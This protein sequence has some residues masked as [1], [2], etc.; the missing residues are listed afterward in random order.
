[1][2]EQEEE[3]EERGGV[4]GPGAKTQ[5][6]WRTRQLGK[7]LYLVC[8]AYRSKCIHLEEAAAVLMVVF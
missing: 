6:G 3:E 5:A 4:V 8:L 1:M 7:Y 2:E